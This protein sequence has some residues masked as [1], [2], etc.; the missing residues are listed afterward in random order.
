LTLLHQLDVSLS[1]PMLHFSFNLNGFNNL[2]GVNSL[3][4]FLIDDDVD[5]QEIFCAVLEIVAPGC[6]C[7]TAAN[8]Q[9]ALDMLTAGNISPDI[10]FLDLN[11]PLMNGRQFLFE[12]N[13]TN[14]AAGIPIVVLTTSADVSTRTSVLE[15]GAKDFIT[16]P[17]R[18]SEWE[19]V[20]KP[21]ISN[22]L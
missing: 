9:V 7:I 15:S 12:V 19:K 10:I 11:M 16:K 14:I 13:R 2:S 4:C 5:D 3:T 18:F 20:L 1:L 21:V 8:G 17:D 22:Y 6:N